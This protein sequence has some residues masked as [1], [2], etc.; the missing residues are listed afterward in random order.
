MFGSGRLG[1]Y[2]QE[3]VAKAWKINQS[4]PV[5]VRL[6]FSL[7]RYLDG[8]GEYKAPRLRTTNI[9]LRYSLLRSRVLSTE[10]IGVRTQNL[11]AGS[12]TP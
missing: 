9:E 7:S 4:E 5:T 1:R 3:T 12:Q 8:P 10:Y 6:H 11:S 2:P